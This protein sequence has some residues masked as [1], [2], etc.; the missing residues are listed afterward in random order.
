MGFPHIPDFTA[1]VNA[2]LKDAGLVAASAAAQVGGVA[3][4]Y[5][6]APSGVATFSPFDIWIN[7]TAIEVDTTDELYTIHAQVSS[8]ATFASTI[9]NACQLELGAAAAKT[10]TADI[11]STTGMYLLRGHNDVDGTVY[12]YL[13]LYTTVDGTIAGG[14]GI[15]YEAWMGLWKS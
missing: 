15:N 14:G 5:D 2:R 10:G 11:V 13:R 7:L 6:L 3:K 4:I 9:Y 12:R 8:S 1:D